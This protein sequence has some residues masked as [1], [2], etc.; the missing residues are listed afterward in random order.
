MF[1][2]FLLTHLKTN[3]HLILYKMFSIYKINC[4]NECYIGHT[5][6][7]TKR[8][9]DHKDR[10]KTEKYNHYKLYKKMNDSLFSFEILKN[11]ECNK[12]EIFIEEQKYIDQYKPTLNTRR[13]VLTIEKKREI[14]KLRM[15]ETV[16][17]YDEDKKVKIAQQQKEYYQKNKEKLKQ[18]RKEYYQKNKS[19]N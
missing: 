4:G 3:E 8:V 19:N 14:N 5:K 10:M 18:K 2:C 11:I 9:Y 16:K 1:N 13:A 15:R 12:K 7:Y 17:N 6:N